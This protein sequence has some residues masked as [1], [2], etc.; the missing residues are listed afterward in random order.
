MT[1][2]VFFSKQTLTA[3]TVSFLLT[4]IGPIPTSYL[5]TSIMLL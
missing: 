2:L 5:V 3:L 1:K 4:Q